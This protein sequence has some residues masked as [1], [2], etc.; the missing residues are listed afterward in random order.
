MSTLA[1]R[2]A[3]KTRMLNRSVQ[4]TLGRRPSDLIPY[5]Y[6]TSTLTLEVGQGCGEIS[7]DLYQ[8]S[9]GVY[10]TTIPLA[11]VLLAGETISL[12]TP[13]DRRPSRRNLTDHHELQV[14]PGGHATA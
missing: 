14:P 12:E 3:A 4:D 11:R 10:A 6:D 8:I 9:D 1:R 5:L 13:T 2:P 7:D